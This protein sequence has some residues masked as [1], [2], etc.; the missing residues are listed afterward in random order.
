M[1]IWFISPYSPKTVNGIG[2]FLLSLG[3]NLNKNGHMTFLITPRVEKEIEICNTFEEDKNLI[4][5][6]HTKIKNLAS[7]HLIILILITL[8]KR[9]KEID[10][11]HLQQPYIVSA[12]CSAFGKF[13]KIP[14]VTT[15]H[16]RSP[17]P[18]NNLKRLIHY[19][20]PK[21]TFKLSEKVTF[22]SEGTKSSFELK[23]GLV[24]RNGVDIKYF[25]LNK[26]IREET[27][28]SLGLSNEFTF[29]FASRWTANKGIYELLKAFAM[30]L[31]LTK[32]KVKLLLVGSGKGSGETNRV[33]EQIDLL[34]I[35]DDVVALGLVEQIYPYYCSADA[36]ILPSYLE[37]LPMSL[38]EAMSCGLVPIVSRVGGNV[39]LIEDEENG[40]F[41]E[42]RNINSLI[43]KMLWC[44]NNTE[45]SEV[46]RKRAVETVKKR[47]SHDKVAK[48]YIKL[49]KAFNI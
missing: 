42:P 49:Y 46:V 20:T 33:L 28:R 3:K 45:E 47:F 2:T 8:Y 32:T 27:R 6:E 14:V 9:R 15:V 13:L 38:L 10:V 19:V 17:T 7:V 5:I 31:T 24:I 1:K 43:Q 37:G 44:I 11:I 18:K 26:E 12:F 29:L 4:E 41:V 25:Q 22:V 35:N 40:F 48:K 21:L 34:G 36:F 39:E 30:V 16:L 23:E